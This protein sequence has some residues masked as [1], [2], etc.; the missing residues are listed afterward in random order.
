M[1]FKPSYLFYILAI[2]SVIL[3]PVLK[4]QTV[5]ANVHDTYFAITYFHYLAVIFMLSL[6]TGLVYSL[7]DRL[8]KPIKL[9]TGIIHFTSIFIGHIFAISIYTLIVICVV[10]GTPIDPVAFAFNKCALILFLTGP[11]FLL[12][13]LV[14]FVYGLL[15]AFCRKTSA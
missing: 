8:K 4:D 3:I 11:F 10:T 12:I 9:T 15:K 5:D 1:K 2:I 6:I 13:G 14:V 7:M